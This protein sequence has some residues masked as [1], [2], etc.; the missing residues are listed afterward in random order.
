[1]ELTATPHEVPRVRA[2]RR[3]LLGVSVLWL[4]LA[5]LFDGVTVLLLPVR[6]ASDAGAATAIGL[7]SFAGLLAAML[8]QP[9]AGYASDRVRRSVGR[10]SFIAAAALPIVGGL[11]LFAGPLPLAV[12]ALGY[13]I[14]QIGASAMQAA[15]QSLVPEHV[16]TARHGR[17]SALRSTLGA[18]SW[19]SPCSVRSSDGAVWP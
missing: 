13:V 11:W 14:V 8:V 2:T 19:R 7:L 17:A 4:P 10:R 1:M 15:H 3:L 6:F 5:F 12:A 16:E 18:R 9:L